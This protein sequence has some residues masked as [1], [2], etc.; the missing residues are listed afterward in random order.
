MVTDLRTQ[1]L[2]RLICVD[3]SSSWMAEVSAE[4]PQVFADELTRHKLTKAAWSR[5]LSPWK[6]VQR[7]HSRLSP[8]DV[9][10]DGEQP[11]AAH[12]VWSALAQACSFQT[13]W[14]QPLRRRRHINLSELEAAL[15]AEQSNLSSHPGSRLL[16]GCDSQ[17][18]LGALVKGRSSSPSLNTM[19][20]RFLPTVI[21]YNGYSHQQYVRSAENVADDPTR[22]RECRSPSLESPQWLLDAF[23]GD[24]KAMDE[25]LDSCGLAD[26]ELARLPKLEME[27]WDKELETVEPFEL[28]EDEMI[29]SSL[30]SQQFPWPSSSLKMSGSKSMSR[31]LPRPSRS[32]LLTKGVETPPC[33]QVSHCRSVSRGVPVMWIFFLVAEDWLSSWLDQQ[34]VL[35]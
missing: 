16:M 1:V 26:A 14:R 19:M 5:L 7:L 11:A 29:P 25:F 2:P 9:V 18:S 10:P 23:S 30:T 20:K 22:D 24:F 35:Y 27:L 32:G 15:L 31:S 4:L 17:V 21:G 12:P 34:D 8:E 6:E 3:A 33:L 28:A 13:E